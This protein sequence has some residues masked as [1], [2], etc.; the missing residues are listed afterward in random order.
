VSAQ[1]RT[2]ILGGTF[3][4]IHLGHLAVADAAREHL[5]LDAVWVVPTLVPPHRAS[6]P[7]ASAYHRFAMAALSCADR[8]GLDACDIELDRPGPSYTA[9]TL[10]HL[11]GAGHAAWQLFFITG[12][13]AFA[14]IATW[15]DY[16]AVMDFANFV[17]VSRPSL[18]ATALPGRLP[19]LAARMRLAER[20][21]TTVVDDRATWI[22]L[23][24]RA[25]PDVSSTDIR[26]RIRAGRTIDGL[27]PPVVSDY[28]QR[29]GLYR[30]PGDA[31]RTHVHGG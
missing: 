12:A 7:A 22:Y 15:R 13:D 24:D 26:A 25:T 14:E 17:I 30:D 28:I 8:P 5:G 29:H 10:R 16:P 11:H 18:A 20:G 6:G 9:D 21:A 23:V 1:P 19:A 27:V 2:G 31:V 4:P 3:D